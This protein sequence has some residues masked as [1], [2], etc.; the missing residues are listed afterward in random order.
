[1]D[2]RE[3]AGAYDEWAASYD[4]D[5][6]RTRDLDAQ[7]VRE[8]L[9]GRRFD[10]V[11]EL[12][13]GTGKNTTFL[14]SLAGAVRAFDFSPGMLAIA[15]RKV[16]A[17][18]VAFA[19]ADVTKSW[20]VAAGTADLVTFDLVLE[21]VEHLGPV[22]AEGAR[23]LRPG[24]E[25]FLCEFHPCRQYEGK[26]A[27]FRRGDVV[28][29]VCAF[30]HHA[31]DYLVAA[32]AAGLS[33][34]E[35]REWWH[36]DDTGRPPRLLSLRFTKTKASRITSD[37]GVLVGKPVIRGTRIAVELVLDHLARGW[38]VEQIGEQYP[39]IGRDEVLECC[40]YA[41]ARIRG[42]PPTGT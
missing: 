40:R 6:N 38:T 8:V 3:I 26:Q 20:P 21:H 12:G 33:L 18:N 23:V 42:S 13:C 34:R 24:G 16:T 36:A 17:A 2:G 32:A 15:A 11:V 41:A 10:V 1:M 39:G 5:Q 19:T 9:A 30:V 37:P 27:T 25:L 14:A 22:L 29:P 31:S 4:S 35:L 7:V 28:T